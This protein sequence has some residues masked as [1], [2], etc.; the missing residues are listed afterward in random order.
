MKFATVSA[1]S[2]L[3]DER[4][5]AIAKRHQ[6]SRKLE[7]CPEFTGDFSQEDQT[8]RASMRQSSCRPIPEMCLPKNRSTN[9]PHRE[10]HL[11]CWR[12]AICLATIRWH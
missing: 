3:R 6:D 8:T 7:Q 5:N 4:L 1:V 2:E 9:C 12:L 11:G 10:D